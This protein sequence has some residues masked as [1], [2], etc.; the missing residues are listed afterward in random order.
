MP[1]NKKRQKVVYEKS[2]GGIIFRRSDG[3]IEYLLL[4]YPPRKKEKPA[5]K[6]PTRQ[7]GKPC[8]SHGAGHW[9]YVKG[10]IEE[11]ESEKET[12]LREAEEETNLNDD[13]L[14]FKKNFKE[15]IEYWFRKKG[16]LVHKIVDFYL[17]ESKTK[18]IKLSFEHDDYKWLPYKKA[19]ETLTFKNAKEVL[20][21]AH[22]KVTS[23]Q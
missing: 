21:K 18:K 8:T 2:V 13:N 10:H 17:L 15:K 4:H 7:E 5:K 19:K 16:T 12:L 22:K 14:E 1:K 3:K 6:S 23:N 11:G 9:D 20:E